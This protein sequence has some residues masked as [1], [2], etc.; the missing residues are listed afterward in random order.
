[1]AIT[2]KRIEAP[3][4]VEGD[5][6]EYS[7]SQATATMSKTLPLK[8]DFLGRKMRLLS[9]EVLISAA[10]TTSESFTVTLDSHLGASYD[11][12]LFSNNPSLT[13]ATSIVNIWDT[14]YD[15]HPLDELVVAYANTNT[16]TVGFRLLLR[17]RF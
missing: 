14:P 11:V 1:M 17:E 9:V 2:I 13:S 16:N 8:K 3:V 5:V 7:H 4:K 10:P 15:L 6:Y 12:V